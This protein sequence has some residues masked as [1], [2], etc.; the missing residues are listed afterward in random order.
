MSWP[1][2]T[3]PQA[4]AHMGG[5]QVMGLRNSATVRKAGRFERW[6]CGLGVW[7]VGQGRG[8]HAP[9]VKGLPEMSTMIDT[10]FQLKVDT[11]INLTH[12]RFRPRCRSGRSLT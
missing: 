6:C 8:V 3:T 7:R 10:L 2:A 11:P 4:K 12:L 9:I 1:E 5:N